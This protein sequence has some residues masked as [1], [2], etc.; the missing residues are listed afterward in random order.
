M[1]FTRIS[2]FAVSLLSSLLAVVMMG[3]AVSPAHAAIWVWDGGASTNQMSTAAN[4]N[5]DGVP[6]NG[7]TIQWNGTQTGNLLLVSNLNITQGVFLDVTAGQTGSLTLDSSSTALRLRDITIAAGSGAFSLG[8]GVGTLNSA[9]FNLAFNTVTTN[10]FTNNSSNAAT[11]NSDAQFGSGG[12]VTRALV[13]TGTGNWNVN[14]TLAP[15]GGGTINVTKSGTGTLNIGNAAA[16]GAAGRTFTITAGSIDNTT[17]GPLTTTNVLQAWNG[18]FTFLGTNDLNLGTGAVTM[19]ATRQMTVNANNLTVG[20]AIGGA[21]FGLTKAGAGTLT[22]GGASTYSGATTINA[23]KLIV[24]GSLNSA[25]AVA[26]NS[27]TLDGTGT[28]GAVTVADVPAN[29]VANGNGGTGAMTMSSLAFGGDATVNVRLSSPSPGMNVTGALSTTPANGTVTINAVHTGVWQTGLNSLINYGSFGGSISD[30]TLGT[31]S[32]ATGPRFTSFGSLVNTGS[33]I[34]LQVNGDVPVWS[35]AGGDGGLWKTVTT[36][37][38]SGP[39]DW[40][41]LS[42]HTATNFWANDQVQFNDTYDAGGGPTAPATTTV[43]IQGGVSPNSATFNNSALN[44]TI[45]SNDATGIATGTLTKNGT[46]AVTI[47]T[48]NTYAGGTTFTA[49]TI[50]VNNASALGTGAITIATGSAKTLDA[51]GGAVTLSTNNVQNWND[52][53]TFAGTNELNMGTGTVTLSGTNRTVTVNNNR[54]TVGVLNGGATS[55]LTVNGTAPL[56]ISGTA[57]T[58]ADNSSKVAGLSGSGII[59]N[60]AAVTAALTVNG[61][62]NSTFTGILRD[63]PANGLGLIK[64]GSGSLTLTNANT[65]SGSIAVPGSVAGSTIITAGTIIAANTQ[66]LGSGLIVFPPSSTGALDIALNPGDDLSNTIRTNSV[67]NITLI[68]N[69]ATP[70]ADTNHTL[71][72]ASLGGGSVTIAKGSNVTSGTASLSI[73]TVALTAGSTQTTTINPTTANVSLG[74]VTSDL[75]NNIHTLELGGTSTGNVVVGDIANASGITAA[76]NLIKSNTSTW[77][78]TGNST[79]NGTTTISGGVLNIGDGNTSGTLAAGAATNNATLNFNRSDALTVSSAISGTT[80][81]INQIGSGTTT[82]SGTSTYSGA[83][84]IAAGKLVVTGSLSSSAVAVTSGNLDGTGSVGATTVADLAANTL[85]NGNGGTGTFTLNALTFNGDATINATVGGAIPFTVTNAL[86]T[87]PANGQVTINGSGTWVLGLNN[88]IGYGSFGGS[89][90]DFTLGSITGL[91]SRQA[92]GSLV[93]TGSTIALNINGDSPKWTGLDNGNWIIGATGANKNWKLITGGGATDFIDG[94]AVLFDDTAAGTTTI[95]VGTNVNTGG[96]TF[97]N[98][99]K[100]YT[101]GSAGSFAIS[102][103][104]ALTKNGSGS[105]AISTNNTFTGSL[106]MN[107]GTLTLSGSNTNASTTFN[108]GTLNIGNPSAIGTGAITIGTGSAKTLDNTIGVALTLSANATVA[109]NDDFTFTG[110]GDGSHDLDLGNGAVTVG[111]TGTDRTV[112]VS[113]GTLTMGEIRATAQ[114]LIKQGAGTLVVSS[115]GTFNNGSNISGTLNLAAGTLQINRNGASGNNSGDF[116]ATGLTGSGTIVNGGGDER[117]LYINT[118]A[119]S[120]FAGTL[121]DG[122]TGPLG[123]NKQG[124]GTLTLSGTNTYTAVTTVVFGTLN[125]SGSGSIANSTRYDIGNGIDNG[126]G[127][128]QVDTNGRLN[129]AAVINITSN[130]LGAGP[131]AGNA[132][133]LELSGNI[134]LSNNITFAP[135]N[136]TN[137]SD[138]IRNVSGNNELSGPINITTGG[139]QTRIRSD[140]GLL[141]LSGGISTTATTNPRDLYLQGAG[142][143]LVSGVISDNPPTTVPIFLHKE[144]TGTWT[145]TG[146]NTYTGGTII[147]GGTLLANNTS[148]SGTGAGTVTVNSGGTL[149]GTGTIDTSTTNANVTVAAGGSLSPGAS[150]GTLTFSLGTGTL[151]LSAVTTGGLKFELGA[152][153]T[154]STSD[155]V[156]VTSGMLNVGTLDFSDF[157]FTNAGGLGVGTYKLFDAQSAITGAIGSTSGT[158]AGFAATISLDNTNFDVLLNVTGPGVAGDYN[159]NGVVDAADYVVWRKKVGAASLTN[160]SNTISGPVGQADYDFWRSRFGATSG[161]GSMLGGASVPEPSTAI[162]LASMML[163]LAVK[164]RSNSSRLKKP[165]CSS[166]SSGIPVA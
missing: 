157:T 118:T 123:L 9:A 87:T 165:G 76:M 150:A 130:S 124:T 54:L 11:I 66:A 97:N 88:L 114:G 62:S 28:I 57:T 128:L 164:R 93:N 49:G 52:D 39:N 14:T 121:A 103:A 98:T 111:G 146:S 71:S 120:T 162:L 142:N 100:N 61:S 26:L 140:A 163:M 158:I 74:G 65:Y 127:V 20:G 161:S 112:T 89:I 90:S 46:G 44:Y 78:L 64:S 68:P 72:F 133:R 81:S 101:I 2:A 145:L 56:A 129:P 33:S 69:R 7:D 113:A 77:T 34:A 139:N 36:G 25:G 115:T 153:A 43:T 148:G 95:D 144:G 8:N 67:S 108:G 32:G 122:G 73:S 94:D 22:L 134:L 6:A 47:N 59:E 27:G 154:P 85:A 159:S 17:G 58:T 99:T 1:S 91:N 79:Y 55:A 125:F 53:F 102:G 110:A 4:Y 51:T 15:S 38:N 106:T 109:W 75:N 80:G 12:G 5:P 24:T 70:G 31:V 40:A 107:A 83:T 147:D 132:G 156:V 10:T 149:G 104:G 86:T 136:D 37:D 29:V 166:S 141:T 3:I 116:M 45:N 23:G 160:R 63:G 42:A 105:V 126:T 135:R 152:P 96:I 117:W 50:N 151:N 60:N 137:G 18:D 21:G 41:L 119:N 82:L 155:H 92:V 84:N 19:N 143:G 35:G 131:G 16:L 138:G 30:F 48:A 13:L